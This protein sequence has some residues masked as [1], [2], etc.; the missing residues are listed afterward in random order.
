MN[1]V[2][3]DL[4]ERGTFVHRF[5]DDVE[6]P[7]Q[8]GLADRHGDDVTSVT[9]GHPADQ[10]FGAVHGDAA[11]RALAQVLRDFEDQVPLFVTDCR[12]GNLQG[13]V[14][15][16]QGAVFELDVHHRTHHLGDFSDVH[17][18]VLRL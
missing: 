7:S 3:F 15:R 18:D 11:D 17:G 4:V 9:H 1:R 13:I 12:V 10:P 8:R 5:A 16:R 14:D 2:A 6:N